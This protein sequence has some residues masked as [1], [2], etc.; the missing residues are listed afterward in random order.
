MK[1]V[2]KKLRSDPTTAVISVILLMCCG[3]A[4][5][6]KK[7]RKQFY[8]SSLELRVRFLIAEL[9]VTFKTAV[10][11]GSTNCRQEIK[12]ETLDPL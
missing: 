10:V 12:P 5:K 3:K 9:K 8:L 2:K 7:E 4:R 11:F 1:S 6:K